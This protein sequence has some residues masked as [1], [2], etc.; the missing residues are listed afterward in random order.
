MSFDLNGI[1]G[2]DLS[3][4]EWNRTRDLYSSDFVHFF[5]FLCGFRGLKRVEGEDGRWPSSSLVCVCV[6]IVQHSFGTQLTV[7]S[8]WLVALT[9]FLPLWV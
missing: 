9:P 6:K 1:N 2:F 4:S 7:P 5:L 3:G 8:H